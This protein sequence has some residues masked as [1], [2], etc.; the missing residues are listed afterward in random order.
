[1]RHLYIN[2]TVVRLSSSPQR[3]RKVG[4]YLTI[5]FSFEMTGH[6]AINT[7]LANLRG[8]LTSRRDVQVVHRE[9][10]PQVIARTPEL[11]GGNTQHIAAIENEL[12]RQLEAQHGTFTYPSIAF[13][14]SQSQVVV[15]EADMPPTPVLYEASINLHGDRINAPNRGKSLNMTRA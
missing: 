14:H 8:K 2:C 9:S 4:P 1:M 13:A 5:H 3:K 12:K 7:R 6:H 10:H 11:Q 15:T